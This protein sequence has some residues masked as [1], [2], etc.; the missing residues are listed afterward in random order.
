MLKALNMDQTEYKESLKRNGPDWQGIWDTDWTP[1][2]EQKANP[3]LVKFEKLCFSG[4][5]RVLIPF[6]GKSVDL[7]YLADKGHD[8]YGSELIGKAVTDFFQESN[9]D[10]VMEKH[11]DVN[12]YKATSKRITFFQGD[13]YDLKSSLCGKFDVIWDRAAVVVVHPHLRPDYAAVI[14]DLMSPEC[15]YLLNTFTF[16]DENYQGPPY[17][18]TSQDIENT[19]GSFCDIKHLETH[20]APFYLTKA[21]HVIITNSLLTRKTT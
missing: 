9:L 7:L 17:P 15:K 12:I 6:C 19:F 14:N 5:Q 16:E 11:G 8:V 20:K 18:L 4:R 1:F 2:H 21:D 10:Y 3:D 13:F